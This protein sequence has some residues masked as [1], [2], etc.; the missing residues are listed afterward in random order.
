MGKSILDSVKEDVY[1][2]VV[3]GAV[4]GSLKTLLKELRRMDT[5]TFR[6]H[7][8]DERNDFHNWIKHLFGDEKLANALLEASDCEGTITA[9]EKRLKMEKLLRRKPRHKPTSKL[10][11]SLISKQHRYPGMPNVTMLKNVTLLDTTIPREVNLRKPG[12]I[13][14]SIAL[15]AVVI[16]LKLGSQASL[17]GSATV[18]ISQIEINLLGFGSVV[19]VLLLAFL[20]LFLLKHNPKLNQEIK[21]YWPLRR[22]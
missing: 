21:G 20:Y 9:L 2:Y 6:H 17:A 18:D 22:E 4:V 3:N 14:G 16:F 15:L 13:V 10:K 5:N 8:N 12:L 19:A 1:F 7:V 11:T